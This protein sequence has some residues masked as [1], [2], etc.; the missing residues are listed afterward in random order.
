MK[1]F[2]SLHVWQRSHDLVLQVYRATASFPSEEMFGLRSQLRRSVASV[3]TNIAEGCGRGADADFA[4][5]VQ[6]ALGSA[7]ETEYQLLLAK[8]LGFL[9]GRRHETLTNETQE[10]K[11][12]LSGLRNRLRRKKTVARL[13]PG[14]GAG[15]ES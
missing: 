1:D 15:A 12:M 10:V 2:R 14:P 8:D 7:S 13:V 5:F 9:D 11:R 3:P 4:R 6:I